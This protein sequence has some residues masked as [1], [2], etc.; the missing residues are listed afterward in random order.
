MIKDILVFVQAGVGRSLQIEAAV[1][2]AKAH[3]AALSGLCAID[4]P[5][6]PAFAEA[7]IGMEIIQ[8][9]MAARRGA[10]KQLEARLLSAARQ[11][12]VAAEWRA[13]EGEPVSVALQHGRTADLV[14]LA[15]ADPDAGGEQNRLEELALT[16]GRPALVVPYVGAPAS[17]GRHAIVAWSATREA[18]RAAHDALPLLRS[19]QSTSVVG[20]DLDGAQRASLE[21]LTAHLA[22][23]GVKAQPRAASSGGLGVGDVLLNYVANEGADLLVMGAYGHSRVREL[24]LGGATRTVFRQ[25][26]APVLFSH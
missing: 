9:E 17:I 13:V 11:A 19:A 21:R 23:H 22:R 5:S 2:L 7:P 4:L 14:V 3:S 25:M 24:V 12:G 18:A 16:L 6:V 10:A 8:E 20:V 15:Q 26:T 1:A